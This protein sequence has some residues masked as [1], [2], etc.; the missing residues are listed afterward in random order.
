M[1]ISWTV[2]DEATI[3]DLLREITSSTNISKFEV[4]YGYPPKPLPIDECQHST[5]L[6]DLD[7]KLN[8]EQLTIG[9]K[10]EPIIQET[11]PAEF[12]R[13]VT[14]AEKVSKQ[15]ALETKGMAG[16]VPE[17]PFPQRGATVGKSSK[18][19]ES[20]RPGLTI[21]QFCV[22]CQMTTPVSSV[23][24]VR[25]SCRETTFRCQSSAP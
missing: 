20:G 6:N 24:L 11:K 3:S 12:T 13:E 4:K 17:I 14:G 10:D 22:S 8:G 7:V 18:P 19:S 21:P 23:H 5:L 15:I 25:R 1:L 16:D 9:P 2:P